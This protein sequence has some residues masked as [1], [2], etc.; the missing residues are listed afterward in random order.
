MVLINSADSNRAE[1][2]YIKEVQWGVTPASG[3]SKAARITSSGLVTGKETETSQE[4][5]SDRMTPNIIEVA[6]SSSGPVE[7]EFSAGAVDDFAEAVLAGDWTRDLNFWQVKGAQVRVVDSNTI[8]VLGIDATPYLSNNQWLKL[9]GFELLANNAYVQVASFAFTGGNTD[10]D[11]TGATLAAENGTAFSKVLDANDVLDKSTTTAITSG[12]TINGGGANAFA[13]LTIK[14]GQKIWMTHIA[15]DVGTLQFLATDP[16]E[17]DTILVSDGVRSVTFEIR[18]VAGLVAE[19]NVHV[20]LSGTPNTMASNFGAAV[21][22]QFARGGLQVSASVAT[23]TVTLTNHLVVGGNIVASGAGVSVTVT[24]FTGGDLATGG[25]LTVA[26][27]PNDDT[28]VT[29]ETLTVNANAGSV[30]VTI[31]GSH[32]RN[33]DTPAEIIR[34]SFSIETLFTDVSKNFLRNGMRAGSFELNVETGSI[35]TGSTEFMGRETIPSSTPVLTGGGYTVQDA[36]ATDVFNATANVGQIFKDGVELDVA[37][38]SL[39]FTVDGNLREQRAVG[40]KF[41]AGIGYGRITIEG[42]AEVYFENFDRYNDFVNHATVGLSFNFTDVDNQWYFFTIPAV[43]FTTNDIA[44]GGI[45]EDVK[46]EIEFQAQ[47]DPVLDTMFMIDRFSSVY[48]TTN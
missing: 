6:A 7:F 18:T 15:K 11:I 5:R 19:G 30:P 20:A 39:S 46:E 28:I 23:D 44:P 33:E 9:E 45:D 22:R 37:I 31:K 1:V 27:V 16:S 43:K 42:S 34:Q 12:N 4:I 8:R 21:Q 3:I 35:V 32:L 13:G 26:S 2:R 17:G 40:E 36:T 38:S 48:P 14:V 47:R 41:P 25:F 29:V 10:I 24:A